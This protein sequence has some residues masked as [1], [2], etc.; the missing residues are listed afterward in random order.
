[1]T[2]AKTTAKFCGKKIVEVLEYNTDPDDPKTGQ[3]I[4]AVL[5][6]GSKV[7]F[8]IS[9]AEVETEAESKNMPLNDL[10][11]NVI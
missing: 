11:R 1:M 6:D 7:S 9:D 3:R 10:E 8:A 2:E 5:E 4:T